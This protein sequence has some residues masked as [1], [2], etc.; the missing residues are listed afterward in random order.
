VRPVAILFL[1]IA[2]TGVGEGAMS[3]LLVPFVTR[4]LSGGGVAYGAVL[5]AQAIGGLLGNAVIGQVGRD[6]PSGRLLGLGAVGLGAIDLLIFNAYRI[7][8]GLA[9][10]LILMAIVGLPAAGIGVGYTTLLQT[11]VADEYRGRV[12]GAFGAVNALS[13]LIG[14]GLA[15]VLGDVLGI[16]TVLNVQGLVY[17]FAG[18]MVLVLLAS[19]RT[20]Q[21]WQEGAGT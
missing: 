20:A 6:L 10:P 3:T 5:A 9:A 19:A 11:T 7:V 2:I 21:V 14:S 17:I 12:F 15:G 18:A 8:P 4:I 1:F 16:V 13:L